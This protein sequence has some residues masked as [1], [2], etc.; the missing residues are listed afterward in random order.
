L[1]EGEADGLAAFHVK[2]AGGNVQSVGECKAAFGEF[3]VLL[4]GSLQLGT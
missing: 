4:R 2:L 3:W 1:F